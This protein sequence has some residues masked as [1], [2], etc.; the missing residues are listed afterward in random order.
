[1]STNHNEVTRYL[2]VTFCVCVYVCVWRILFIRFFLWCK[3]FILGQ[4]T[5]PDVI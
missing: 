3:F 5:V 1:M 4:E 2:T